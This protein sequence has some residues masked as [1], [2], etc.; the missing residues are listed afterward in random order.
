MSLQAEVKTTNAS[1]DEESCSVPAQARTNGI[2][3]QKIECASTVDQRNWDELAERL[4]GCFSHCYAYG[5][6]E[7]FRSNVVPLFVKAFDQNRECIGIAVGSIESPKYW[8]FSRFCKS[9]VIGAL[10]TTRDKSPDLERAIMVALEKELKLRGVFRIHVC[11][12]DSPNSVAVLSSLSYDLHGR[13]EFYLDLNRPLEDIWKMLKGARRTHIRKATK[14]G[15]E[16]RIEND[17]ASLL[18]LYSFQAESLQ[19]RGILFDPPRGQADAAKALLLDTGRAIVL[20]SYLGGAP[21]N[22]ALFGRF[23]RKAY[24]LASGA[25]VSGKQSCGPVH[26]LW[27]MIEKLKAAGGEVLNL[28]GVSVA[29]GDEGGVSGLYSFKQDFGATGISQ[30]AGTKIISQMGAGLDSAYAFLHRRWHNFRVTMNL[31]LKG[32]APSDSHPRQF[33]SG[34]TGALSENR[35]RLLVEEDHSGPD[36]DH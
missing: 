14:L 31:I 34:L 18:R 22:A 30:P 35:D 9:A 8:P 29:L 27:T 19:R 3:L 20:V 4:G 33:A 2:I 10:P 24:Y 36:E 25:T 32:H 12:Y 11:S 15:V 7:S 26:L 28:G 13:V 6:Y 16:T 17:L 21:V 23:G 5:V 1:A